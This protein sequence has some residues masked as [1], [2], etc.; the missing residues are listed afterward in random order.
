ML[1][2]VCLKTGAQKI[3]IRSGPARA[4]PQQGPSMP[5]TTYTSV[6]GDSLLQSRDL[7]GAT[8]M[9]A[10]PS[11]AVD[12][13][14]EPTARDQQSIKRRHSMAKTGLVDGCQS[15]TK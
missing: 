7:P 13:S 12:V 10:G 8:T 1:D 6:P 5:L 9:D 11:V 3:R 2:W 14:M 4:V 15:Q